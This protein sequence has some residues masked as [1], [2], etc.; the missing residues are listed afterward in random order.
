MTRCGA[1]CRPC[2]RWPRG[3]GLDAVASQ[4]RVLADAEVLFRQGHDADALYFVS[5]GRLAVWREEGGARALGRPDRAEDG[6]AQRWRDVLLQQI[7][8]PQQID[9]LRALGQ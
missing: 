6:P 7:H 8:D 2:P 4:R 9:R 3:I 1:I 5:A